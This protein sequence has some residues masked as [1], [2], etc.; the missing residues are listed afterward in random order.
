MSD[1]A[2]RFHIRSVEI[3]DHELD[4]YVALEVTFFS[5]SDDFGQLGT[6]YEALSFPD[7]ALYENWE[8]GRELSDSLS[9]L[10][11]EPDSKS[12]LFRGMEA[13]ELGLMTSVVLKGRNVIEST[14]VP[15]L[16][17]YDG[18]AA[19]CLIVRSAIVQ[20]AEMKDQI[21][22]GYCR[23]GDFPEHIGCFHSGDPLMDFLSILNVV[24]TLCD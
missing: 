20:I 19:D 3:R 10:K 4:N 8:A 1:A 22:R 7:V 9:F 23:W 14:D 17:R 11:G 2:N 5:K 6:Y 12:F 18:Y 13:V 24:E 16:Y 15:N 21:E